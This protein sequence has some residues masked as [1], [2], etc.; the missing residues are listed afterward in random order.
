MSV[1]NEDH[2]KI[3][4]NHKTEFQRKLEFF[5]TIIS[6]KKYERPASYNEKA[7]KPNETFHH[8]IPSFIADND[9]V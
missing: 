2:Q 4:G 6:N 5:S 9:V 8:A 3:N 7:R 1:S